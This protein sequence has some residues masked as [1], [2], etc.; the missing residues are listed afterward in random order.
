MPSHRFIP[1]F[2]PFLWRDSIHFCLILAIALPRFFDR[3]ESTQRCAIALAILE[4]VDMTSLSR[5]ARGRG[6][7]AVSCRR[8]PSNSSPGIFKV[9]QWIGDAPLRKQ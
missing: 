5:A 7:K 4:C 1:F 2:Y 3:T 8:T 6:S 9:S